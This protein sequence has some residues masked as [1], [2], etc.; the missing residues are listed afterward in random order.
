MDQTKRTLQCREQMEELAS[1][2]SW[3]DMSCEETSWK[4]GWKTSLEETT[5]RNEPGEEES[6]GSESE[7]SES[8]DSESRSDEDEGEGE[9]MGE[10]GVEEVEV[11][12][13]EVAAAAVLEDGTPALATMPDIETEMEELAVH[14]QRPTASVPSLPSS[15]GSRF[16]RADGWHRAAAAPNPGLATAPPDLQALAAPA[17]TRATEGQI[18]R[19][20]M[21]SYI[22]RTDPHDHGLPNVPIV[23]EEVQSHVPVL[24]DDVLLAGDEAQEE[25][26]QQEQGGVVPETEVAMPETDNGEA[27]DDILMAD[28]GV[29]QEEEQ[30]EQGKVRPRAELPIPGA[31]DDKMADD[32]IQP[33]EEWPE[34]E[35][36]GVLPETDVAMLG[37]EE[38]E[39]AD[40]AVQPEDEQPEEEQPREEQPGE[41]QGVVLPETDVSM[42]WADNGEPRMDDN[43]TAGE[44]E[45]AEPEV[46][47]AEAPEGEQDA[48]A[49][50]NQAKAPVADHDMT[51]DEP[52][53]TP[54]KAQEPAQEHP[55]GAP[56]AA[57]EEQGEAMTGVVHDTSGDANPREDLLDSDEDSDMED[58]VEWNFSPPVPARTISDIV[59]TY[60]EGNTPEI[61]MSV[62]PITVDGEELICLNT[63]AAGG[64]RDLVN[65]VYDM[66]HGVH[67]SKS[68]GNVD[69]TQWDNLD[70]QEVVE[71][72][73]FNYEPA[74]DV[75]DK[76]R[77]GGKACPRGPRQ[78][79]QE[80]KDEHFAKTHFKKLTNKDLHMKLYRAAGGTKKELSNSGMTRCVRF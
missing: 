38:H 8:E 52:N 18:H 44:T 42:P 7:E 59:R 5:W 31:E 67:K 22:A 9:E 62:N 10:E 56:D 32:A 36:G 41:E 47:R 14:R 45:I 48:A 17:F 78:Q 21:N 63:S 37:T 2:T 55:E 54:G 76:D 66:A 29:R 28:N 23:E 61:T 13:E 60:I 69:S 70:L 64:L 51:A 50:D 71:W 15:R 40:D 12:D 20:Q 4:P 27:Q 6:E 16:P 72:R 65:E 30:R 1:E 34:E 58:A 25:E 68:H 33:E 3:E 19:D 49:I 11:A 74:A 39:M 80:A 79:I 73:T 26:E 77:S 43:A 57:Y 53:G 35:Q 24:E 75:D 46:E